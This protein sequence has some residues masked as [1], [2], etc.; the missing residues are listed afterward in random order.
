MFGE[1]VGFDSAS[2]LVISISSGARGSLAVT[3]QDYKSKIAGLFL[4]GAPGIFQLGYSFV[5]H[6]DPG[7]HSASNRNWYHGLS[8]GWR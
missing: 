2:E 1:D 7:V 8:K 4:D 6:V 5:P 3:A